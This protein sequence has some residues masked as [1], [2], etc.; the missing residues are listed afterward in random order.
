MGVVYLAEDTSLDRLVA[1][2]FLPEVMLEDEVALQ[3]FVREAK[4][5]AAIDHPYICN[6]FEV[7]QTEDGRDFIAMEYI[8]GLTLKERLVE[9]PLPLEETLQIAMHVA[10]ALE[11]AHS[12]GIVHRDLKPANIMLTPQ[13]HTKV[14][15]FGLA[16]HVDSKGA[17]PDDITNAATQILTRSSTLTI[18]G[19]TLGTLS[20]M[21]PEQVRGESVDARSDIFSF[22]IV[23]Y[24]MLTG[25]HPFQKP[26]AAETAVSILHD[27][28]QP[29]AETRA[30]LP[31]ALQE[32]LES[33]LAKDRDLRPATGA[34][35]LLQLRQIHKSVLEADYVERAK[36]EAGL[37]SLVRRMLNPKIAVPLVILVVAALW[38]SWWLLDRQ[39]KQRW[40]RE[41]LLPKVEA[42]V[43]SSWRDFTDAYRLA[44]EAEQYI[45]DD[46]KLE[47]LFAKC[48]LNVT[49][50]TE[51]VGAEVFMKEYGT[52]DSDW[53]YQ[54]VTPLS[55][56]RVPISVL[57]WKLEKEGFETVLAATSSWDI[58]LANTALLKPNNLYRI[59]DVK[60]STRT[61]MV[62]VQGAETPVG[63]LPDFFIDRYEVTN[64]QYK[65]FLDKGGY[66]NESYWKHPFLR[67]GEIISREEAMAEFVDRTNRPGPATWEAGGY[68]EEKG[69]Y[70]VSGISWYEAAAYAEFSGKVLP[71][72]EH[73][74]L[75]RGEATTLIRFPQLGGY[76]LFAPF[77]NYGGKG[78]VPAGSLP[79]ITPYGVYDMA[80]NV[81]EW[82]FNSIEQGRV[83]RG[84]AWDEAHYMF[85]HLGQAPPMDRSPQNGFRCA[86]Y[87]DSDAIPKTAF[88]DYR[89]PEVR[90]YY[91]DEPV[92]DSVFEI[93]REGFSYDATDLNA[94]VEETT[95]NP[96][97]W[98]REKVS[99]DAAYGQ[100]RIIGHL[101][102]PRNASPPYQTVIYF[103]GSGSLF[104]P[105]SA[106]IEEYFEFPV[107]LSFLVRS[108][109][110]VLFPVFK[111][112]FERHDSSVPASSLDDGSHR[113]AEWV[114]QLGK[115][116]KRCVDYLE[117]R[118]DIDSSKIAYYGMSWGG[119]MGA[120]LPAV[121]DRL[122][123]SVLLSGGILVD[124]V[125]PEADPVNYV[126]RVR[127]PTLMINGRFDTILP[128][129]TAIRPLYDLLGTPDEHKQLILYDTDHIP[130]RNEFIKETLVWLD[131]YMGPVNP[132]Q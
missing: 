32:S 84:G 72:S 35:V 85:Q 129:E 10:E 41:E 19:S 3:R 4:S 64:R 39:A 100:E 44:I 119:T 95:E 122:T 88:D 67:G 110:A 118:S 78:L 125:R 101:F 22:G 21:S 46:P 74:G 79:G 96:K 128:L 56:V 89:L 33:M 43:E 91:G 111:G 126:G 38:G 132:V 81:R 97:G 66:R 54:G 75:A 105:S 60:G 14:M 5:A 102:L 50:T 90:D 30:D 63:M 73:W 68:P 34:E 76:A 42:A 121:E 40:A 70:P 7:G 109:R 25:A 57:R 48:S 94:R 69:D 131:R 1:L 115:D 71:S 24:Q 86:V 17:Y 23:L 120:I 8:D 31:D 37:G 52:P 53:Q 55:Q 62:R 51:P 83:V 26:L 12:R 18:E 27:T 2:K 11:Q 9:G 104:Q 80:G 45:P 77:S 127:V 130:P 47:E 29:L 92:S 6:I 58:D 61:G 117:T 98:K 87:P 93:Y 112:T 103:P 124:E 82:C 107:F 59:L 116:L 114:A 106:E 113:Y 28:P 99:F 15:D 20:Y 13:G 123:A 65:E 108:G 16:K 36:A 49:V